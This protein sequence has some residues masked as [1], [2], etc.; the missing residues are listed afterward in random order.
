MPRDQPPCVTTLRYGLMTCMSIRCS[1][2][3]IITVRHRRP[4]ESLSSSP[5]PGRRLA[6]ATGVSSG[7][8]RT[9]QDVGVVLPKS[10]KQLSTILMSHLPIPDRCHCWWTPAS[11]SHQE[12]R[13]RPRWCPGRRASPGSRRRAPSPRSGPGRGSCPGPPEFDASARPHSEWWEDLDAEWKRWSKNLAG[14]DN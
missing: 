8:R 6:V 10:S 11:P 5:S 14:K 1:W 7:Q 2:S 12:S 13:C 3:P 4:D 9:Q